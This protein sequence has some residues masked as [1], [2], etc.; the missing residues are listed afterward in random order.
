MRIKYWMF[1][2]IYKHS[3][4]TEECSKKSKN[5]NY[6]NSSV[7]NKNKQLNSTWVYEIN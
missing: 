5:E 6:K 7:N 4:K 1:N 2:I 3:D